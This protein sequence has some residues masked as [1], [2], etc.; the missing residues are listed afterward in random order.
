MFR[1]A[2]PLK[3]GKESKAREGG[4]GGRREKKGERA[5]IKRK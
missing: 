1:V 2:N 3:R 4:R 5:N